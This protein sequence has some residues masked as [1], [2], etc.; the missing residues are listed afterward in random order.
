MNS[1]GTESRNGH[2]RAEENL[3]ENGVAGKNSTNH[4]S[5]VNTSCGFKMEKLKMPRFAGDVRD[6]AIFQADF[7]HAVDSTYSKREAILLLPTSL[8]RRPLELIKGISTDHDA[9]WSYLDSKYRDSRFL[10]DTI[11]HNITKFRP[12]R[13]GENAQFFNLV[14]L[15]QK[16]FSTLKEVGQLHDRQQ[17]HVGPN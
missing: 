7:R 10:A 2:L 14:H 5:N 15:L 6:Y 12:P 17:P 11:T 4:Q 3:G 13:D 1:T 16:R 9:T 8:Q